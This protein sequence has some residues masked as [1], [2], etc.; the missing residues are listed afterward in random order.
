MSE[1]IGREKEL[2]LLN[3]W[4]SE[5][6]FEFIAMYGRRRVG[7]TEIIKQ[8]IEGKPTIF[9]TAMRAKGNLNM[10]MFNHTVRRYSGT[11]G[12]LLY[13]DELFRM[14]ADSTAERLVLVIDEFPYFAESDEDIL[15]ALQIFIDHVAR[16]TKIFLILCGSSMSFMKRQVLG[17]ESP[18]YGRRT[19]EMH[20]RPMNFAESSLFLPGKSSYEKACVYGAVGGIPMYLKTFS[21]KGD[22]FKMIAEEFFDENSVMS[23]EPESLILQ[24]LRDPKKY[25]CII[26]A[27]ATG[28]TRISEISGHCGIVAPETSKCL[29]DLISLGYVEKVVPMN[30]K[31][32]RKS[33][34]YLSDNLFRFYYQLVIC[35]KQTISGRSVEETSKNLELKFQEYMGRIFE[36][37]CSQYIIEKMGYPQTGKW[38]GAPSKDVTA[39]IDVIGSVG[40]AGRI[41]GLF[42]ECKFTKRP[43]DVDDL[44]RLKENAAYVKGFDVKH[45]AVFSRSG[46]TDRLME[47]AEA[48]GVALVTL[49]MMYDAT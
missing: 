13:F 39:E 14:I 15:S 26:E 33:R 30:E 36:T 32:E 16:R 43:A 2:E 45:Y 17:Y 7:K 1:F 31:S 3:R 44:E 35:Q 49:D 9:F 22:I 47:K 40:R 29:D 37:M 5:D 28:S 11:S 21:G 25:N 48:E 8:F 41:E 20:V 27:V 6:K 42:A 23:S 10:R 19:H 18:L 12:E 46:F 24:E 38:W 34:Y 4:Y